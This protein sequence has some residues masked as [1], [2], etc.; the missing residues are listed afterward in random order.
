M[1]ALSDFQVNI[2]NAA[3]DASAVFTTGSNDDTVFVDRVLTAFSSDYTTGSY[4]SAVSFAVHLD[5]GAGN[6]SVSAH[7]LAAT[8]HITTGAGNDT[9]TL[10]TDTSSGSG[11]ELIAA[12]AEL[13]LGSGNDL[14]AI[15]ATGI[16]VARIEGSVDGG[17]GIDTVRVVSENGANISAATVSN[18][19][20][21]S[22]TGAI[23][24]TAA[25]H[26]GFATILAPG[27]ADAITLMTTINGTANNAIEF[28]TLNSTGDDRLSFGGADAIRGHQ[29]VNLAG[30]GHDTVVINNPSFNSGNNNPLTVTNFTAGGLG[31]N[32]DVLGLKLAGVPYNAEYHEIVNGA[33]ASLVAVGER[34]VIAITA[35]GGINLND[36][37]NGGAIENLIVN[38]V[39]TVSAFDTDLPYAFVIYD[40]AGSNAG[41]YNAIIH[42][43]G[44][45]DYNLTGSN[46]INVEHVAALTGIAPNA[47]TAAN[48][49][50]M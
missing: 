30:G 2:S 12:G 45:L 41:I 15:T 39:G 42:T 9:V 47:L 46:E 31:S 34:S 32:N 1:R 26:N 3:A 5:T 22:L 49:I 33:N 48:F 7:H 43:S 11:L 40:G 28:Y 24:M 38:S 25:Q 21:L 13:S 37:S 14:L 4:S 20:T 8:A 6:D 18:V 27:A 44:W 16:G 17:S 23:W 35:G 36:V 29:S 50:G 19:E 10:T